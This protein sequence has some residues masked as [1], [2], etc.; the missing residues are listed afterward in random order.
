MQAYKKTSDKQVSCLSSRKSLTSL[1]DSAEAGICADIKTTRS[2]KIEMSCD[3]DKCVCA[4][5]EIADDFKK[6]GICQRFHSKSRGLKKVRD[7]QL[8]YIKI[9]VS[10]F[11]FC[12]PSRRKKSKF[13]RAGLEAE[14]IFFLA[15]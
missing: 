11:L 12:S 7:P 1:P 2:D 3:L 6:P 14:T 4:C 10:T 5:L 13:E 9:L 8:I 15:I